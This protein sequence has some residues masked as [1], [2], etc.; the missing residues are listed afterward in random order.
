MGDQRGERAPRRPGPSPARRRGGARSA[1]A[2][3]CSR[4]RA[5]SAKSVDLFL[6]EKKIASW[7]REPYVATIPY[8]QY[9][10]GSFLRATAM[11]EDGKEANDIFVRFLAVLGD[12]GRAQEAAA[13]VRLVR[14]RRDVRL[15]RPGRDLLFV[16][17]EVDGLR[18]AARDRLHRDAD[19][20]LSGLRVGLGKD[21]DGEARA[22]LVDRPGVLLDHAAGLVVADSAHRLLQGQVAQVDFDGVRRTRAREQELSPR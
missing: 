15:T 22:P 9:A 7:T 11:T 21:P 2:S 12:R 8:E 16:E 17:E 19:A 20:D 10:R 18:D 4:S 6:D 3:R 13:G 14:N 5:A 1:S